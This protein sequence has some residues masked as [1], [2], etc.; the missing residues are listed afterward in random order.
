MRF[1]SVAECN[2]EDSTD[3]NSP[4]NFSSHRFYTVEF[5]VG[6]GT[7]IHTFSKVMNAIFRIAPNMESSTD[8]D[9][10]VDDLEV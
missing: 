3:W 9:D 7:N 8:Y 1:S 2:Y 4:Y 10:I 5:V 6:S